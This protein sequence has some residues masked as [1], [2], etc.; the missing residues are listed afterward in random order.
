MIIAL[1]IASLHPFFSL[2]E[3][4]A[5]SSDPALAALLSATPPST[6][7]QQDAENTKDPD[8]RQHWRHN[9]PEHSYAGTRHAATIQQFRLP[10]GTTLN[11]PLPACA[12][13]FD[14]HC[15]TA[16]RANSFAKM[17]TC[18]RDHFSDLSN[19]CRLYVMMSENCNMPALRSLCNVT[20]EYGTIGLAQC[21][22]R[23]SALLT[24]DP[25][26]AMVGGKACVD[27]MRA[28]ASDVVPDGD[29]RSLEE[30]GEA[31]QSLSESQ[32][33][34][35]KKRGGGDAESIAL[36]MAVKS[37]GLAVSPD[38]VERHSELEDLVLNAQPTEADRPTDPPIDLGRWGKRGMTRPKQAIVRPKV[39]WDSPGSDGSRKS[40]EL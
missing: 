15:P 37:A 20:S 36:G 23:V 24:T 2:A 4:F 14:T 35:R 10:N 27:A 16:R 34:R 11:T 25:R 5:S 38:E 19:D 12:S 17:L 29:L 3:E 22:A 31:K 7:T 26:S 33:P 18:L 28:Q 9:A 13:E 8:I 32:A 6:S 21:G 30:I 39:L 40:G 1:L